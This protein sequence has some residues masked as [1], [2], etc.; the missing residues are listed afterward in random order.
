VTYDPDDA[1]RPRRSWLIVIP[2][3]VLAAL[4]LAWT[5][6][7][8]YAAS[9]ADTTIAAWREREA[10]LGRTYTCGSQTTGG[11]PFRIELQCTDPTAE[12]RSAQVQAMVKAHNLVV[13]MQAYDPTLVIS[14]LAGPLTVADPGRPPNLRAEW[15]SARA[16]V[17]GLPAAPERVSIVLEKPVFSRPRTDGGTDLLANAEHLEW[18]TRVRSGSVFADPVLELAVNLVKATAPGINPFANQPI[19]AEVTAVLTGLK[20]LA[21]KPWAERFRELQAGNGRLEIVNARMRQGDILAAASGTLGVSAR[22][23][24]EGELQVTIAGLDKLL[25]A[26]G[27]DQLMAAFGGKDG[28]GAVAGQLDRLMP[29]LGGLVRGRSNLGGNGGAVGQPAQIDGRAAVT[30]PLRFADGMAFLGPF[31]LGQTPPLF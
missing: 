17:R 20:D 10:R 2:A 1:D 27:L 15:Q 5:G 13:T 3:L 12:V 22:G 23:R 24:L 7:W 25:P 28:L 16:S 18:H 31:Q 19:D 4:A 29:G 8:Y 21:P 6:F 9:R 30:L 26:L 11:F 14:E